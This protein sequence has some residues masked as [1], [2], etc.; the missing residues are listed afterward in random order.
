LSRYVDE[1]QDNLLIDTLRKA[2]LDIPVLLMIISLSVLR[3]LCRRADGLFWAGDTAQTISVGSSFR[4][5]DLKAF[6]FRVEVCRL[7]PNPLPAG[8]DIFIC[9][10]GKGYCCQ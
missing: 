3:S 7:S 8:G 10:L 1:V 4:F 6:I 9:D 2:F 5:D